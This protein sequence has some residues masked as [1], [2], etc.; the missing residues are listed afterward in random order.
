MSAS[1]MQELPDVLKSVKTRL[2]LAEPY[3][4]R[5]LE[6]IGASDARSHIAHNPDF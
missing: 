6:H 1:L 5:E 4:N 2:N 3:N